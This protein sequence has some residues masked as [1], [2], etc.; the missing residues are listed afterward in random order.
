VYKKIDSTLRGNPAAE[1]GAVMHALGEKRAVV[2]PAFPAQGRMVRCGRV[3]VNGL[4]LEETVFALS[5]AGH[6]LMALFGDGKNEQLISI[7]EVRSGDEQLCGLMRQAG[8]RILIADAETAEDLGMLAR[9]FLSSG[10][11]IACGSAGFAQALVAASASSATGTGMGAATPKPVVDGPLLVVA[12]SRHP[13]T[14]AQVAELRR[15]GFAVISPTSDELRIDIDGV[16]LAHKVSGELHHHGTACI[17]AG[18]LPDLPGKEQII[19]RGIAVLAARILKEVQVGG[20]L[21]TGGE[22]AAAVCREIGCGV[23]DLGGEILPGVIW[24]RLEGGHFPGLP[25]VTKAGG[26]G[27]DDAL[28]SV[29]KFFQT[30]E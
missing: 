5:A 25:V 1:L 20:L 9:S 8:E 13:A 21:L 16:L 6:D 3:W 28:L 22:T 19:A 15:A 11:H 7:D 14:L 10:G 27:S 24:G 30:S 29:I 17:S 18:E 12:G 2:A 4:P 23:I 26:F